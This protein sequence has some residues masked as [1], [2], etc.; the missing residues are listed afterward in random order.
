MNDTQNSNFANTQNTDTNPTMEK[1]E[2]TLGIKWFSRLGI[3]ALLIGA[4][5][6][7]SYSFNHYF[8]K[9]VKLITGWLLASGLFYTGIKIFKSYNILART[10]QGG[11]LALGYMS[12]FAMFFFPQVQLFD[13][14]FTGWL[15]LTV[16][17]A[18]MVFLAHRMKSQTVALLSLG[19][20]YF[21]ASYSGEALT[22]FLTSSIL[23]SAA[24]ALNYYHKKWKA[25]S[26]IS[27][28]CSYATYFYWLI[29]NNQ[30]EISTVFKL[31]N[32]LFLWFNFLLFNFATFFTINRSSVSLSIA[33]TLCFYALYRP[34]ISEHS[35]LSNGLME[36][37]IALATI[38]STIL[39]F[40]LQKEKYSALS[41]NFLTQSIIFTGLATMGAFEANSL[42]TVLAAEALCFGLMSKHKFNPKYFLIASYVF[43]MI[44]GFNLTLEWTNYSNATLL[45]TSL[46]Y[47]LCLLLLEH[48]VYKNHERISTV[49]I[50]PSTI[51]IMFLALNKA[52]PDNWLTITYIISGLLAFIAGFI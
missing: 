35:N 19:F 42:A 1:W 36:A 3:V 4:C 14:K 10:L 25:L 41:Q 15:F 48:N 44:A 28:F 52:L 5:L 18:G 32:Q 49:I 47:C 11:G 7:L 12:L 31:Q 34:L 45:I 50:F 37:L 13:D 39:C 2:L 38:I 9:E 30:S 43:I 16:Y 27:L 29:Q 20:G 46:S 22:T 8:T 51:L 24:I 21:T 33:N 23:S 40:Y 17:V 26:W 6:A